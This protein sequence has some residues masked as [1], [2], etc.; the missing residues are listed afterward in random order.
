MP[1]NGPL[2]QAALHAL[3]WN[4][5]IDLHPPLNQFGAGKIG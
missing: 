2:E 5:A 4:M 3:W 1:G